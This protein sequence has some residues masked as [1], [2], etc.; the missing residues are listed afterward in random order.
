M[1]LDFGCLMEFDV[2]LKMT[3][4]FSCCARLEQNHCMVVTG[5]GHTDFGLGIPCRARALKPEIE[6]LIVT[7]RA[8]GEEITKSFR[9]CLFRKSLVNMRFQNGKI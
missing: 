2:G 3:G 7:C 6:E 9:T 8:A 5:C 1:E 4:K